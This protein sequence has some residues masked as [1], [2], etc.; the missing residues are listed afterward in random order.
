MLREESHYRLSLTYLKNKF[1]PLSPW[2]RE[3]NFLHI[4]IIII[5]G[6][7][8]CPFCL[9]ISLQYLVVSR[10]HIFS[11]IFLSCRF[12]FTCCILKSNFL[13]TYSHYFFFMH[14]TYQSF[15][16]ANCSPQHPQQQQDQPTPH[17]LNCWWSLNGDIAGLWPNLS[18]KIGHVWIKMKA[19]SKSVFLQSRMPTQASKAKK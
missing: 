19:F 10:M 1:V 11:L 7:L 9:F 3:S 5:R 12:C 16:S 15:I 2:Y 17:T 4:S 6:V 14:K 18:R 8:S 13:I